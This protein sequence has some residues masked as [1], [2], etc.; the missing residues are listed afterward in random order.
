MMCRLLAVIY[1]VVTPTENYEEVS[2]DA[3]KNA[4]ST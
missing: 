3:M 2:I 1:W 4:A